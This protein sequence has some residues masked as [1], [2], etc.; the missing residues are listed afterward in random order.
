MGSL[1][2][3]TSSDKASYFSTSLLVSNIINMINEVAK[4][5]ECLSLWDCWCVYNNQGWEMGT[6]VHLLNQADKWPTI[7]IYI[8]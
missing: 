3:S 4:E 2:E 5:P 8:L 7:M 6:N 1:V